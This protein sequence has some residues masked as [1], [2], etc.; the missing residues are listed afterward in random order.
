MYKKVVKVGP[1]LK[2]RSEVRHKI[3]IFF[4]Y[5]NFSSI[6]LEKKEMREKSRWKRDPNKC[7]VLG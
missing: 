6:N 1:D 4:K 3:T 2:G 7:P 5:V